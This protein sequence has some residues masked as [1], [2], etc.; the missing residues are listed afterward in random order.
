MQPRLLPGAVR[1]DT[2]GYSEPGGMKQRAAGGGCDGT[3]R[4]GA[5]SDGRTQGRNSA[6]GRG[7]DRSCRLSGAL[8]LYRL[9]SAV[10]ASEQS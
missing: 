5:R 7:E 4:A 9:R 3:E 2:H 6:D 10:S 1:G 8:G